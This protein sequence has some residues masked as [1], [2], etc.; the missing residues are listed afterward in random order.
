MIK[1]IKIENYKSIV[2]L[3]LNLGRFNVFIGE[4]GCGKSNILEA[5]A[6]AG[7]ASQG[8]MNYEYLFNRGIRVSNPELM[9]SAFEGEDNDNITLGIVTSEDFLEFKISYNEKLMPS[10][11]RTSFVTPYYR[12]LGTKITDSS[13]K[14]VIDALVEDGIIKKEADSEF[15]NTDYLLNFLLN[16]VVE[17]NRIISKQLNQFLLYFPEYSTL[18]TQSESP[19]QPLGVKGEGLLRLIENFK[20][21]ELQGKEQPLSKLIELLMLFDW[22]DDLDIA[23]SDFGHRKLSLTDRYLKE[24]LNVISEHASNEGFL[25]ALFYFSLFISKQ[26]PDFFAIDNIDTSLNPKLCREIT[27]QL[28]I[29][30]KESDKQVIVTTHNPSILDGLNLNDDEQRLFVV[31]RNKLGHTKIK[32]VEKKGLQ[33]GQANVKLSEAFTRG[34]IGGLPKTF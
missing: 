32:R 34:Y 16:N 14:K 31:S 19:L 9:F 23:V 18:K 10:P 2:D 11:W 22:F 26:T 15:N 29:L 24:G 12:K 30:A 20:K 28:A 33:N 13:K 27:K 6:V 5:I 21:E 4:N 17:T 3:E 1:Q 25:F 8:S 7:A